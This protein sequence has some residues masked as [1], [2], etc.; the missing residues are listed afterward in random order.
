V[1]FFRQVLRLCSGFAAYRDVLDVPTGT[2]LRYLIQLVALL[3][4][5]FVAASIPWVRQRGE[6]VAHWYDRHG[7]EFQLRAGQVTTD[8]SQPFQAGNG[9]FQLRLDTTG[10]VL[11][12]AMTAARGILISSENLSVW[13]R[14]AN[15]TNRLVLLPSQRLQGF[16]DGKVNGN[17]LRDLFQSLFWL[18]VPMV[19]MGLLLVGVVGALLQAWLFTV[20][21]GFMERGAP[22]AL[23][24]RQLLNLAIHAV[25]PGAIVLTVYAAC[26]LE[27]LDLWLIY[28]VAYGIF[29]VGATNACHQPATPAEDSD[30]RPL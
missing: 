16:P 20:A 15:D 9:D 12:S 19:M 30:D 24:F 18:G 22:G 8:V 1:N 2:A 7:P 27:G 10:Q 28:L 23:E 29:V 3:V 11:T 17:Y 4:I 26:R 14:P 6:Q 5:G 25:T 21:A 13:V